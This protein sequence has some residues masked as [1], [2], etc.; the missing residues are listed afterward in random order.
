MM[1]IFIAIQIKSL[2]RLSCFS[3]FIV[4][5][6]LT[7]CFSFV[8]AKRSAFCD[9]VWS[10]EG[11]KTESVGSFLKHASCILIVMGLVMSHAILDQFLILKW[12]SNCVV[13]RNIEQFTKAQAL[14][15]GSTATFIL[16]VFC[17]TNYQQVWS[18]EVCSEGLIWNRTDLNIALWKV[19]ILIWWSVS[20]V[21]LVS[22]SLTTPLSNTRA[23]SG[24]VPTS[25]HFGSS[26]L[27]H[28]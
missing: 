19:W 22:A 5:F 18:K 27:G 17:C 21:W 16:T 9:F 26:D 24:Y 2:K 13:R 20:V 8:K 28:P 11:T 15:H 23:K 10:T 3:L 6:S 25:I 14:A 7:H 1:G 12:N 4:F